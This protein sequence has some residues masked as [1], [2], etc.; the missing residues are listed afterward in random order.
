[1]EYRLKFLVF[2]NTSSLAVATY[3]IK[4]TAE[5]G[6]REFGSDAKN[7]VD[8]NFYVDGRPK[9]V[10]EPTEAVDLLRRTQA[11]LATANLHLHK[12]ASNLP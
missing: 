3:C 9:S 8:N 4:K 12:I 6:G 10:A 7:F 2:G 5:V 1:M 11:M